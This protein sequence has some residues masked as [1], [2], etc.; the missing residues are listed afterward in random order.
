[1][2]LDV[3]SNRLNKEDRADKK[4]LTIEWLLRLKRYEEAVWSADI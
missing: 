2:V 4:T 3:Y 1:M